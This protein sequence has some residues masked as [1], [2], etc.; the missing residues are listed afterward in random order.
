M[1]VDFLFFQ[2][3]KHGFI[4]FQIELVTGSHFYV[5]KSVLNAKNTHILTLSIEFKPLN[6]QSHYRLQLLTL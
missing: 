4:N 6:L 2:N 5:N 1:H 3:E